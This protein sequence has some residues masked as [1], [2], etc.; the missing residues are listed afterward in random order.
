MISA[1]PTGTRIAC[2]RDADPDAN[3]HVFTAGDSEIERMLALRDRLR[4][5][6]G[7]RDRYAH[8]DSPARRRAPERRRR[9]HWYILNRGSSRW[10]VPKLPSP[11]VQSLPIARED[12]PV[13]LGGVLWWLTTSNNQ[14][15]Q[16]QRT[17]V[18]T[19]A[20]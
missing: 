11:R 9:R 1:S 15:M 6:T 20:C 2:S 5:H 14:A 7:D 19:I 17:P 10:C 13:V 12:S 8:I 3:V 4:T 18:N 16:V